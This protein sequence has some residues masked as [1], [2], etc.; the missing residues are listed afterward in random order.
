MLRRKIKLSLT[1]ATVLALVAPLLAALPA[2]AQE[3][4]P[5][6][7]AAGC[8]P[9]DP[10]RCL[11]P[12]PNNYFTAPDASTDTGVRV[13][14]SPLA[15]PR[16]VAGKPIDPTE[17]NRNDGFSPGAMILTHV[18]GVDLVRTGAPPITDVERSLS[19]KSPIALIDASTG[20]RHP[21]W[22]EL[23]ANATSDDDRALII[24]PAVNLTEGHRYIVA[25]GAMRRTDGTVIASSPAFAAYRDGTPSTDPAIEARRPQMESIFATL[26]KAKIDRKSLYLAWDFT[27][28]SERNLTER[29]LH[30]R[31]DA[32]DALGS[33]SADGVAP[34]FEV[35]TV[36]DLTPSQDS[37]ISR[38]IQG[39]FEVPNYL[40][41]IRTCGLQAVL[42][43]VDCSPIPGARFNYAGATDRDGN[44]CTAIDDGCLPQ[45]L[46]TTTANFWCDVPRATVENATDPTAVVH[47]ARA[48]LY[49]HGLLGGASEV[50]SGSQ[51]A[52]MNEHNFVYCATNWSGMATEDL[53]NVAATLE[54]MSNFGSMSDQVQ[55]GMLNFLYLGRLMIDPDGFVSDPAFQAGDPAAPTPVIDARHGNLFYDGNS[56]GGIIGGALTAVAQDF[57]RA[58]LGVPGMNYSTLLNRSA[59]WEADGPYSPDPSG[60]PEDQ[61]P[62]YAT[63][64]YTAY[65]DK[66]DE[67]LIFSMI[68]ML[69]D[70][71]EANGYAAHMTTDPLPNTP[72]HSV[73]MHVAFGDHQV[74]NVA[75][76]V[77]ARTI[78]ASIYQPAIAAGRNPD[79]QPYWGLPTV[80]SGS[81]GS[82][83]VIWDSGTPT[84]PTT[85]TPNRG[86]DD[87]HSKPRS[88]VSARLQ[89]ATF[90]QPSGYFVDVCGGR[91]CLAP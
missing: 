63:A 59:D 6:T 60:D 48:S 81:T 38:R 74:T 21:F 29:M 78:G 80:A 77:E 17:W 76:E 44:L 41:A 15:T 22:A 45:A 23:D 86:G 89:K 73:L 83:I 1:L 88:Q 20:K 79:V 36:T 35:S 91:P 49:G 52:M 32:F 12:F 47:P 40:T 2:A 25:L 26:K 13:D 28:A 39:T 62:A 30:I 71:S 67:Q 65:P 3:P 10:S 53:P 16:N 75:A 57:T 68:Q 58:A 18:P 69:W 31:D 50:N 72:A 61:L 24:R 11:F 8:D 9:I 82:A 34:S 7:L 66:M 54:D 19:K 42:Q 84:P 70:R 90:L 37:Q 46:G 87:P 56:Q 14:I 43:V 4:D 27:V 5:T 64:M 55:Q 85:N 33:G 51:R